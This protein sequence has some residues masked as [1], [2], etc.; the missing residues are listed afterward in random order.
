[1][2]ILLQ[3]AGQKLPGSRPNRAADGTFNPQLSTINL[4]R[5]FT[6]I[7]MLVVIAILGLLAGL[8]V[9]A[10]KNM[11]KSDATVS[12][13]RQLLDDIGRARQLAMSRRTTVY[14]VFVPTNFYTLNN[15]NNQ[16]LIAGLNAMTPAADKQEAFVA[17]TNLMGRQLSGYTFMSYGA[18]GDQPGRHSWHYL[19][20]WQD[21]PD[22]TFIAAQKFSFPST[23]FNIPQWQSD[24]AGRID[25]WRAGQNQVY[26]FTNVLVPFPTEVSPLVRMPYLAFDYSGRLI[27]ELDGSGNYHH[28]YVPLA[29]GSVYPAM[30]PN[31][32]IFQLSP[33]SVLE[34]P[35]GNSTNISYNIIDI[36]PLTGRAVL[37]YYQIQ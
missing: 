21:L 5:A 4:R 9:P 31:T 12:A 2:K 28:A 1:M 18:V 22:G 36:D 19:A 20:A 11:G 7:E 30:D 23:A 35:P 15:V 14:M 24:N 27:S 34:N 6:L 8:A 25:N 3:V 37:Q 16:N 10:L 33:A 26:A 29:H 32:K 13:A 17:L